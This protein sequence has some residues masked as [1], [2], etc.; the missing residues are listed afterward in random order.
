MGM[1]GRK[2]KEGSRSIFHKLGPK[3]S[4]CLGSIALSLTDVCSV[5]GDSEESQTGMA[6]C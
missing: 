4:G 5:A 1:T 6:I 3:G 2:A